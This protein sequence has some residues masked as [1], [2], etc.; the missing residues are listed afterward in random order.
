[1]FVWTSVDSELD[2][3]FA[4]GLIAGDGCFSI[5]PNN[6]GSSWQLLLT[7]RLRA[8]DTPL[9]ARLCRWSGAGA[10]SAVP[11]RATSRP[12]TSWAVQRQAD[13]LRMVSILDRH[14]LLGKKLGEYGIW[15]TALK[16]GSQ[17]APT[18]I[19]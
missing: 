11:A 7:V 2:G 14:E 15:R 19:R 17:D 6:G 16:P 1:V 9:L 10:L 18:G 12:Q 3:G 4:A 8:D 5:R 13:C